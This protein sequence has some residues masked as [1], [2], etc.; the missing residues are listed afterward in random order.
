MSSSPVARARQDSVLRSAGSVTPIVAL[1][2]SD[3]AAARAVVNVLGDRCRF[4]KV[5]LE[6]FTAEGTATVR[7]LRET[8][9]EV[10]LDLKLHD[11]PN[12]VRG[13]ARSAARI[14][15]SL[16]TVHASGGADMV[17]AAVEG[18]GEGSAASGVICGILGVT[19]LTSM[20][21]AAV[22]A[23]W[24][25]SGADV[26]SEVL[27][28][29]GLVQQGGGAGIVCSGHEARAVGQRFGSALGM[30]IPGIRLPGGEAHDQRRVMTPR[31]AAEAGAR[32]II[33]GRSVTSAP[34]PAVA[35]DHVRAE[36]ARIG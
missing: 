15:A 5:G 35:M 17:R 36:L 10:F 30:L 28:L 34:D 13:A 4:Y 9:N 19:V 31:D 24:G 22:D 14:G 6:L 29:A 8:G 16:L 1:D 20:D 27:R 25:R 32:W 12:T 11:I 7:W 26:G 3:G 33:L 23:A 18:A 2:V 21:G